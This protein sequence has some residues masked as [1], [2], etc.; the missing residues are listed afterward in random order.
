MPDEMELQELR[1][2]ERMSKID[3]KIIVMSGKGGVGK[4]TVT[5]NLANALLEKGFKVGVLDTDIHG[6]NIA[7]M[8]GCEGAILGS[9]EDGALSFQ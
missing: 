5:V 1:I 4:S 6:P 8:F 7:K 2:H 9:N 3:R